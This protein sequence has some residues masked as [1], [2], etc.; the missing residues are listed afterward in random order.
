MTE[1]SRE[2]RR[3]ER[4][5]RRKERWQRWREGR[6]NGEFGIIHNSRHNGAWTGIFILLIGL[7]AL[8][9]AS[10][11]DF[12]DW[13]FSWQMLLIAMGFFIGVRHNFRGGSWLMLIII[14]SIFLANDIYPEFTFR[15]YMW[16]VALIVVGLYIILRPRR[17]WHR[18]DSGNKDDSNAGTPATDE[19]NYSNEDF[20][21]GTSIFGGTKKNVISKNFKGGD[22]VNIFGGSELDLMQA[23]F[24]GTAVIEI[25]TVF[26]GTKLLAPSNWSIKSEVVTIFGGL[27]DKRKM[28]VVQESTEK[29]LLL[30]GTVIFGGIE[31]KSY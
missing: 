10:V 28:P 4:E 30:R 7:A 15:R 20:V 26:G 24:T 8:L 18:F 9:K 22:L 17:R 25:T 21:E 11:T 19:A 6:Y 12:P 16:P 13:V 1:N 2:E 27:E 31:I 23:D 29:T 5:Q 3:Q 14:G